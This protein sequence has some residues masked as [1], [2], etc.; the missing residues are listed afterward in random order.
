MKQTGTLM[1]CSLKSMGFELFVHLSPASFNEKL[2]SFFNCTTHFLWRKLPCN[3]QCFYYKTWL[4]LVFLFSPGISVKTW[5]PQ[6]GSTWERSPKETSLSRYFKL[7]LFCYHKVIRWNERSSLEWGN[8]Y[9][10]NRWCALY[11][12]DLGHRWAAKV[13]EHVG[14]V[15]SRS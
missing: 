12:A 5:S 4:L 11:S 15:L 7:S 9:I 3:Y 13:Q 14:A 10:F 1:H 6:S 8:S 2:S